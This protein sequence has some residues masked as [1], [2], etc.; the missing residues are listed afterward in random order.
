[1]N[2]QTTA[3]EAESQDS[4]TSG[5]TADSGN[6]HDKAAERT[7]PYGSLHEERQK[8]KAAETQLETMASHVLAQV[9]E[10]MRGLIPESLPPLERV[11]WFNSAKAT[12]IF[13]NSASTPDVPRTDST[14][15]R[16]TPPPI[17]FHKLPPG[18]RMKHGYGGGKA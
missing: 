17:D 4:A 12:G 7:V 2:E 5:D 16:I 10:D 6:G 14:Q 9:P 13:D 11:A 18:E 15:P 1:M 8:R 3:P